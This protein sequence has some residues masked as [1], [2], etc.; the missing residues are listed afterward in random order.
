[1]LRRY[2]SNFASVKLKFKHGLHIRD[3]IVY[4]VIYVTVMYMCVM[5][6]RQ[7]PGYV[8]VAVLVAKIQQDEKK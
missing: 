8:S 1:L 7:S 6:S 4:K 2:Y 5:L 3:V